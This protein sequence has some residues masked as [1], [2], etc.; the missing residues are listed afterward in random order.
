MSVAIG[1]PAV[2]EDQL[3]QS[4]STYC[5]IDSML[6][7]LVHPQNGLFVR[8]CLLNEL[9]N[10]DRPVRTVVVLTVEK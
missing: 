6:Y 4:V 10:A 2:N 3:T 9:V 1:S 5:I 8:V 7:E